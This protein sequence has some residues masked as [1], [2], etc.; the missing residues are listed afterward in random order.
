MSLKRLSILIGIA[1]VVTVVFF[2]VNTKDAAV[3]VDPD[4]TL[5]V[6]EA[7]ST[8]SS[9]LLL[10]NDAIL[11]DESSAQVQTA[12]STSTN[13][14]AF[15]LASKHCEAEVKR[16]FKKHPMNGDFFSSL[17]SLAKQKLLNAE[18]E[19]N[20][21]YHA[22]MSRLYYFPEPNSAA[23]AINLR[24]PDF[25]KPELHL[26][27]TLRD[28]ANYPESGDFLQAIDERNY[29][30]AENL[31]A[32]I[33][34]GSSDGILSDS[35]SSWP[36]LK[37]AMFTAISMQP[38]AE[39]NK[40]MKAILDVFKSAGYPFH[41]AELVDLDE[42][43]LNK[44]PDVLEH[45]L[46]SFSTELSTVFDT[47]KEKSTNL[48]LTALNRYDFNMA[49]F[50]IKQGV[51][52]F[53]NLKEIHMLQGGYGM[54]ILKDVFASDETIKVLLDS[55]ILTTSPNQQFEKTLSERFPNLDAENYYKQH[56]R[57]STLSK[58][59]D[60]HLQKVLAELV[61]ELVALHT[62]GE[63]TL[64]E[65]CEDELLARVKAFQKYFKDR[66]QNNSQKEKFKQLYAQASKIYNEYSDEL[67][68][69]DLAIEQLSLI[70]E[71]KSKRKID[72]IIGLERSK[73]IPSFMQQYTQAETPE[74]LPDASL[75][76][77]IEEA[78][79][80]NDYETALELSDL[81]APFYQN[82][83]KNGL[84]IHAMSSVASSEVFELFM[85]NMEVPVRLVMSKLLKT[86][87]MQ[88]LENMVEAGF[89]INSVDYL[90]RRLLTIAIKEK[91]EQGLRTLI[92]MGVDIEQPEIGLDALDIA[93]AEIIEGYQNYFFVQQ[94]LKANKRIE[95]SHRQL[96]QDLLI[97]YPEPTQRVIDKY[98]I[99]M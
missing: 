86:N 61:Q 64:L 20:A 53:S 6:S 80:N 69:A 3:L 8:P 99:V 85:N 45:L 52:P 29:T 93:L 34:A 28:K 97:M 76:Q 75:I 44:R 82:Q 31:L 24:S 98:G 37:R 78:T 51:D 68:D 18:G 35:T 19:K 47:N 25:K 62:S 1:V 88:L 48:V 66:K 40:T 21:F 22:G 26:E 60:Q 56:Q 57:V 9:A 36:L 16:L 11:D 83:V 54:L 77:K 12:E 89:D 13:Q 50:W 70:D 33:V 90:N 4:P 39:S 32:G 41:F 38:D 96:L 17:Q 49:T 2:A 92:R 15:F 87:D 58:A 46:K 30:L 23:D 67:I 71:Y 65:N 73:N 14:P 91:H 72:L 95:D 10:N 84:L 59:Q 5:K 94:L 81:L 55:G 63:F 27:R 42:T 79:L 74:E 43:F 7:R